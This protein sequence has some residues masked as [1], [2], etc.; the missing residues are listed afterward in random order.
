MAAR[1]NGRGGSDGKPP[2]EVIV[3]GPHE[4]E[5]DGLTED[6]RHNLAVRQIRERWTSATT[7]VVGIGEIVVNA[8]YDGEASKALADDAG[9]NPRFVRLVRTLGTIEGGPS[10]KT[11]SLARR[12]AAASREVD[13]RFWKVLPYSHRERLVLLPS[14]EGMNDG[15][16]R[17]VEFGWTVRQ[18]EQ[19]VRGKLA[20][21]GKRRVKR[22]RTLAASVRDFD[23]VRELGTAKSLERLVKSFE[24]LTPARRREVAEKLEHAAAALAVVRKRLA[25]AEKDG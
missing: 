12:V 10:E 6:A 5:F 4:N 1:R 23:H 25:R 13:G 3:E 16:K 19:W 8:C 2:T 11:L 18:V 7:A 17:A 15:A 22:G 24:K 21:L 9:Q 14:T 20:E